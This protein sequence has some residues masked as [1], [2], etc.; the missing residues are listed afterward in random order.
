M[1]LGLAEAIDAQGW[2]HPRRYL[3]AA[4]GVRRGMCPRG[5]G[6]HGRIPNRSRAPCT[7]LTWQMDTRGGRRAEV[8]LC[9]TDLSLGR[10]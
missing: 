7:F 4:C 10:C 6:L 1:A 9:P 8:F 2:V 3:L 5:A